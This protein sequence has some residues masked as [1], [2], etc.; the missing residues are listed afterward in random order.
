MKIIYIANS[1]S[2]SHYRNRAEELIAQGN[3]IEFYGFMRDG[4]QP[5]SK[6]TY[7][8][9]TIG[10][11]TSCRYWER[12]RIYTNGIKQVL[13]IHQ[14]D[15]CIFYLSGLDIALI[16]YLLSRKPYLYE[17]CDLMQTEM[18]NRFICAILNGIDRCIIR[19]AKVAYFTS[20]GFL[21]YHFKGVQPNNVQLVPNKLNPATPPYTRTRVADPNHLSFSFVGSARYATIRRFIEVGAEHFPQHEFH[22]FGNIMPSFGELKLRSN[23]FLHGRFSNPEDLPSI[24]DQTDVLIC[25]YDQHITNVRYAEPN[26]LYEAQYF[27]VPIIVS[28]DTY[29]AQKVAQLGIGTAVDTYNDQDIIHC[30]QSF[31]HL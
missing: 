4:E 24:Y 6:A 19:H 10:S 3:T 22:I 25:T 1:I 30:I 5:D 14:Q 29:L 23:I 13:S 21:Q 28:R 12:L 9:H 16:Y 7:P 15:D 17:E 20:E 26:K 11:I 27:H 2:N 31:M 18:H 8:I